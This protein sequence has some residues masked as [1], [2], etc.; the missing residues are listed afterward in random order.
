MLTASFLVVPGLLHGTLR[1]TKHDQWLVYLP[2]LLV[3]VAVMV[4]AI[5]VAEKHR[6]MKAVFV[7]VFASR[8]ARLM[9]YVDAH[10]VYVLLVAL[11]IFFSGFNVME[12]SLPSLIT[13]A[14]PP[15][16][17]G[18]ATG[19]YSSS[20]FLGIFVGG[21]SAAG[22]FRGGSAAVFAL[23]AAIALLWLLA[24]ATMA[25][26]SY[27][28]TR[29]LPIGPGADAEGLAADFGSARRRRRGRGRRR[30]ARLSQGQ[31]QSL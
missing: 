25:P 10:N 24:A 20:Q 31:F 18:T 5:I 27:L 3:S 19:V 8:S 2:V 30:K 6:R 9:L 11:T 4:P 29:L 21:A 13:K 28:T 7:A 15:D 22:R 26:P 17:K 23:T 14:A 12:A 1:V 16:A